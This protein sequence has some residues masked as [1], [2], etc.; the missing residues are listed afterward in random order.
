MD[1]VLAPFK[2]R[3]ALIVL[4]AAISLFFSLSGLGVEDGVSRLV[5]AAIVATAVYQLILNDPNPGLDL[6]E[7]WI[8]TIAKAAFWA[9]FITL[10][11]SI[12][13]VSVI[14]GMLNES[15]FASVIANHEIF[16]TGFVAGILWGAFMFGLYRF[17]A[18]RIDTSD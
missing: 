2:I 5:F 8:L 4:V 16:M 3:P 12:L 9:S 13:A 1:S 15:Q 11:A 10:P 17:L 14:L 18:A 6:S 7:G